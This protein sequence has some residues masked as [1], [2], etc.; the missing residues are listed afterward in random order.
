MELAIKF[1]KLV[2]DAMVYIINLLLVWSIFNFSLGSIP[3]AGNWQILYRCD[4]R[5]FKTNYQLP[6]SLLV[7]LSIFPARK[8]SNALKRY[9]LH[10]G[11]QFN[12]KMS[13]WERRFLYI[14][15]ISYFPIFQRGEVATPV[16]PL[17]STTAYYLMKWFHPLF[18]LIS[19]IVTCIVFQHGPRA[20]KWL[21]TINVKKTKSMVF[22]SKVN[23]PIHP[24]FFV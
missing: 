10:F 24:L 8:I 20:S 4:D 12:N 3:V 22:S 11:G 15:F 2:A 21:V 16:P 23:K 18:L 7:C 5:Q 13:G 1:L 6:I 17:G 19:W 9:F 14:I